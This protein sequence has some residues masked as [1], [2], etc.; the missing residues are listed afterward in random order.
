MGK[1]VIND[2]N[3]E[4][5]KGVVKKYGVTQ[6]NDDFVNGTVTIVNYRKYQLHN[7]VDIVF[8]GKIYASAYGKEQWLTLDDIKKFGDRV[9]KIKL[10]RL[11]KVSCLFYVKALMNYFGVRIYRYTDIKKITWE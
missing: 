3:T 2:E 1:Y 4:V 9:S 11:I 7:E 10:N 6:I 8:E 5:I